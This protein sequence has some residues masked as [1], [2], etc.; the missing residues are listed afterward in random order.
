FGYGKVVT[1]KWQG[2]GAWTNKTFRSVFPFLSVT[3]P[4]AVW[5][6]RTT[7]DGEDGYRFQVADA[8]DIQ[9]NDGVGYSPKAR[10]RLQGDGDGW[11]TPANVHLN[12]GPLALHE[13]GTPADPTASDRAMIYAKGDKLVVAFNDAGTIRY[14]WMPLTGTS[15]TWTHQTT[16]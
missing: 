14:R 6:L 1:T 2:S 3:P 13:T 5:G 12:G 16:P 11:E 15:T 10:W 7:R 9:V 4:G 8:G